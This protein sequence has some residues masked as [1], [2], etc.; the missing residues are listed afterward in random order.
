[1]GDIANI[2]TDNFSDCE[3]GSIKDV[4]KEKGKT[5]KYCKVISWKRVKLQKINMLF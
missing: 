5:K 3:S 4:D 1:M 2:A